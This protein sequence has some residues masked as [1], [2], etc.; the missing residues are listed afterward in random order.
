MTEQVSKMIFTSN[1][2]FKQLQQY[3]PPENHVNKD[4]LKQLFI[5]EKKVLKAAGVRQIIVPKLDELNTSPILGMIEE[6]DILRDYYPY[7]YFKKKKPDS[8]FVLNMMNT[9]H[10]GYL[11]ELISYAS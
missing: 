8:T 1:T 6:G 7:D 5:D 2:M 10:P 9:V 4:F 3:L 11:D